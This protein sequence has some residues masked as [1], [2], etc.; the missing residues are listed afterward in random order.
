[1]HLPEPRHLLVHLF[2]Y[3]SPSLLK[4]IEFSKIQFGSAVS[5]VHYCVQSLSFSL[6]YSDCQRSIN[7]TLP[8][9]SSLVWTLAIMETRSAYFSQMLSAIG[10]QFLLPPE[11]PTVKTKKRQNEDTALQEFHDRPAP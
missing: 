5:N 2:I 4:L 6:S 8:F 11:H 1:M 9:A 3:F 10:S 7:G